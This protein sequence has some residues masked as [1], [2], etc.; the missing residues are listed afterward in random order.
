MSTPKSPR[1]WLRILALQLAL[2]CVVFVLCE[3]GCRIYLSSQG[4]SY[5]AAQARASFEEL[6]SRTHDFVPRAAGAMGAKNDDATAQQRILHPYLGWEVMG[7]IEQLLAESSRLGAGARDQDYE[8]LIVG[9]SVADVYGQYGCAH[10]E[11][12][13][14]ADPRFAGRTI[15]T[16]KYARGGYKQPQTV[17][18]VQYL[19]SLGFTPECVISIDGFNDVALS[20]ENAWMQSNPI[21][22]S[23]M[24]WR[25]LAMNGTGDR[26]SVRQAAAIVEHLQSMEW[27]TREVVDTGA[28]RSA[29]FGTIAFARVRALQAAARAMTK[30]Y[31]NRLANLGARYVVAGPPFEGKGLPAVRNGVKAWEEGS[32]TLRALCEARGIRYLHVLQ[33]TLHDPGAKPMTDEE[34]AKGAIGPQWLDGVT[35]GYPLLREAGARLA[36]GGED[37]VDGSRI[38]EHE[39]RT[40]YYDNCHFGVPGNLLLAEFVAKALL[41]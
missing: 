21:L 41:R 9:G 15:Y 22:P 12:L 14:R 38:F 26:E 30:E 25:T 1:R 34:R 11:D 2:L 37:F 33:P 40:L 29:L 31:G 6:F 20:N 3:V 35:L 16:Y 28:Y 7:S 10:M 8:I 19:L 5:V 23:T 13:L 36:A 18:A 27:W 4:R 32:R 17:I 24:H 39:T